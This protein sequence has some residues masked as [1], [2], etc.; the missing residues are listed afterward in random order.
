[1]SNSGFIGSTFPVG[2]SIY[3]AKGFSQSR[4]RQS[5]AC[6]R[7]GERRHTS[8]TAVSTLELGSAAS[9]GTLRSWHA[10]H[11]FRQTTIDSGASGR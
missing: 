8:A 10:I 7:L 9:Q 2:Y 1:V 5:R 3:L 6:F 4:D 11:Q